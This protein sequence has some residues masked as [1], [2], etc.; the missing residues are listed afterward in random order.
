MKPTY[1]LKVFYPFGGEHYLL[2]WWTHGMQHQLIV[3]KSKS[4]AEGMFKS[5]LD[6]HSDGVAKE[7]LR[8]DIVSPTKEQ[9]EEYSEARFKQEVGSWKCNYLWIAKDYYEKYNKLP[10]KMEFC[11]NYKS[12]DVDIT[13]ADDKTHYDCVNCSE[14]IRLVSSSFEELYLKDIEKYSNTWA[15]KPDRR[16]LK[17]KAPYPDT[18]KPIYAVGQ[19]FGHHCTG[20]LLEAGISAFP[21]EALFFYQNPTDVD[22][23]AVNEMVKQEKQAWKKKQAVWEKNRKEEMRQAE[24]KRFEELLSIFG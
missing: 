8:V 11:T 15:R 13:E 19:S 20:I 9:C 17:S 23:S 12:E 2:R 22:M 10:G 6:N 24:Q 1:E 5:A 3:A 7:F 18:S 21:N 4:Q 14:K 16:M